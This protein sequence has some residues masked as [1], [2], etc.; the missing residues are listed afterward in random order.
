MYVFILVCFSPICLAKP[1]TVNSTAQEIRL[2]VEPSCKLFRVSKQASPGDVFTY[3]SFTATHLS[4]ISQPRWRFALEISKFRRQPCVSRTRTHAHTRANIHTGTQWQTHTWKKDST[5]ERGKNKWPS[6]HSLFVF[7]VHISPKDHE[8]CWEQSIF[9]VDHF[10]S[11]SQLAASAVH[12]CE[13][14]ANRVPGRWSVPTQ[15]YFANN[16]LGADIF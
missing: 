15:T 7:H 9:V 5:F 16:R 8:I 10:S 14:E 2:N 11:W 1:V 3:H 12:N 13:F 4:V 6:L